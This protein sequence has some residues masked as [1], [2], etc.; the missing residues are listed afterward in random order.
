MKTEKQE[1]FYSNYSAIEKEIINGAEKFKLQDDKA[2]SAKKLFHQ[3][4]DGV[5]SEWILEYVEYIKKQEIRDVWKREGLSQL[6]SYLLSIESKIK[7]FMPKTPPPL[8]L[9]RSFTLEQLKQLYTGLTIGGFLLTNTTGAD[10][11][12]FCWLF[13]GI[14]NPKNF[15]SL[16]WVKSKS[17]LAY[18]VDSICCKIKKHIEERTDWKWAENGFKVSGLIGAK[19]DFQKTG[20]LPVGSK[21]I[22][23]ILAKI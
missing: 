19:N 8:Y 12:S 4:I 10:Y 16:K 23:A 14:G 18:F 2:E 17:L 13:G 1:F 22:D 20:Q 3:Q 6:K 7:L 5:P 15:K 21:E 11:K 9:T